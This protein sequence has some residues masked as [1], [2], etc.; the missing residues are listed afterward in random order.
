MVRGRFVLVA[1]LLSCAA[2]S[3][4]AML[5]E[6]TPRLTLHYSNGETFEL[7]HQNAFPR[8]FDPLRPRDISDGKLTGR[9]CGVTVEY[10]AR[11]FAGTLTLSGYGDIQWQGHAQSGGPTNLTLGVSEPV[12]GRRKISGQFGGHIHSDS[13]SPIVDLDVST[14]HLEGRVGGRQFFL[15]AKGD[16]FVG[17]ARERDGGMQPFA[18]YGRSVLSTMPPADESLTLV[19]LLACRGS[20]VEYD[21]DE[22]RGFALTKL[23]RP[24][25]AI[26]ENDAIE[27]VDGGIDAGGAELQPPIESKRTI[28]AASAEATIKALSEYKNQS[29]IVYLP[30]NPTEEMSAIAAA[31]VGI[32]RRAGLN[33]EEQ[34][35]RVQSCMPRKYDLAVIASQPATPLQMAVGLRLTL[36]KF[37]V[38]VCQSA[39][40]DAEKLEVLVL[41]PHR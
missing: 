28:D 32:L 15:A 9:L 36:T 33:V 6:G 39:N 27:S 37:P 22:V 13:S 12:A 1:L 17:Q 11:W 30:K 8:V 31:L 19:A 29:A 24:K 34:R 10:D 3:Q 38:Y 23:E 25:G 21:N 18:I 2:T 40:A 4:T 16:Y 14:D 20:V 35:W 26:P 7:Q 5:S 41:P